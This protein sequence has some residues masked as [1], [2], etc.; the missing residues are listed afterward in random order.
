[1]EREFI[2]RLYIDFNGVN[3]SLYHHSFKIIA[4][5][6]ENRWMQN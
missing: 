2:H 5:E 1:M 6:T 4:K 3:P